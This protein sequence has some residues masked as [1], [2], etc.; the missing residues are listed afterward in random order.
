LGGGNQTAYGI[1]IDGQLAL[2]FADT[3]IHGGTKPS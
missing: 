1:D 3:H 2:L